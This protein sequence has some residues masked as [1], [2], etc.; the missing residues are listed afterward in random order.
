MDFISGPSQDMEFCAMKAALHWQFSASAQST[1][2]KGA[3]HVNEQN[4]L[5]RNE[6]N[7]QQVAVN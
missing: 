2:L 4:V 7:L 6:N 1:T 5:F 3:R